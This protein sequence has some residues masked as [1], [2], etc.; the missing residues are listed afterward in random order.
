MRGGELVAWE[1]ESQRSEHGKAWLSQKVL[2]EEEFQE[3][4]SCLHILL[5]LGI[6]TRSFRCV[7]S[8]SGA[9]LG[10]MRGMSWCLVGESNNVG[11]GWELLLICF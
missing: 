2:P 7:E 3:W 11:N 1:S 9:S 4:R 10:D 6:K 8:E 5:M